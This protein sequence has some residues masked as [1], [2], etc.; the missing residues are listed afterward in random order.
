MTVKLIPTLKKEDEIQ[1]GSYFTNTYFKK[2]KLCWIFCG[3]ILCGI[4]PS[5]I[6]F[7]CM[8][9]LLKIQTDLRSYSK[10]CCG[11]CSVHSYIAVK[12]HM[13]QCNILSKQAL[14]CTNKWTIKTGICIQMCFIFLP[15]RFGFQS[16]SDR[17]V[18]S[19]SVWNY[20]LAFYSI[21]QLKLLLRIAAMCRNDNFSCVRS[22]KV[23]LKSLSSDSLH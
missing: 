13:F 21:I 23:P 15:F 12:Y 8:L 5:T 1:F 22:N 18:K 7:F 2:K 11:S 6:A 4:P 17:F 3:I 19:F 9:C 20:C 16:K 14:F 10:Y